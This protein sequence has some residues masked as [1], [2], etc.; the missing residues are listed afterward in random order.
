MLKGGRL[1]VKGTSYQGCHERIKTLLEGNEFCECTY[2]I[3][4]HD[5]GALAVFEHETHEHVG[6]LPAGYTR[7]RPDLKGCTGKLELIYLGCS[8]R[9]SVFDYIAAVTIPAYGPDEPFDY[10]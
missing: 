9:Y 1:R 10:E 4:V 6:Y 5:N 3:M 8:S 7:H 2:E